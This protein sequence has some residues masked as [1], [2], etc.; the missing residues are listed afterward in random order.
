MSAQAFI[1]SVA[2]LL[3]KILPPPGCEGM[4]VVQRKS[5]L[6][7]MR[8]EDMQPGDSICLYDGDCRE[9]FTL[10]DP[11]LKTLMK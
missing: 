8:R 7:W 3:A 4:V 6:M 5:I 1:P 9:V 2:E 11:R 10:D